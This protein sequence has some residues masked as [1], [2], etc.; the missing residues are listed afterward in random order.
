[1]FGVQSRQGNNN[2]NNNNGNH[3]RRLDEEDDTSSTTAAALTPYESI[4]RLLKAKP[5]PPQ[6]TVVR[7]DIPSLKKKSPKIFNFLSP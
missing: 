2:N 7:P 5:K 1:M 4:R 3:G 6:T